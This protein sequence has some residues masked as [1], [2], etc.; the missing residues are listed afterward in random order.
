MGCE[1]SSAYLRDVVLKWLTVGSGAL[2]TLGGVGNCFTLNPF[3]MFQGVF[4]FIFGLMIIG[5]VYEVERILKHVAFLKFMWGRGLFFLYLGVPLLEALVTKIMG[6]DDGTADDA[7]GLGQQEAV[8]EAVVGVTLTVNALLNLV[9]A[10]SCG[11][12]EKDQAQALLSTAVA[13]EAV[14]RN[15]RPT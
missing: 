3:T 2:L 12:K 4:N 13:T 11:K 8:F 10:F 6:D 7:S 15:S 5:S 9:G 14:L 1:E